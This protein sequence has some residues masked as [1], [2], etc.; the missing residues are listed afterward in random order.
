MNIKKEFCIRTITALTL[1]IVSAIIFFAFP[2]WATS[3]L[4][5]LL[6]TGIFYE[7]ILL[8]R[9]QPRRLRWA[10]QA[11][12]LISW[13]LL[14]LLNQ[15]PHRMLL[16][17]IILVASAHDIGA[18]CIGKLI[19]KHKIAPTISPGKT[20]EGFIGGGITTSFMLIGMKYLGYFSLISYYL[21]FPI[22]FFLSSVATVGDLFESWLKRRAGKKDSGTL[23]PGHGGL[24]DRFDSALAIT[25]VV[26]ILKQLFMLS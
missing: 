2:L 14:L 24:F 1:I 10:V 12:I 21:I 20:W 25:P 15:G 5:I 4:I 3:V 19:G 18:Y 9:Q 16:V 7:A 13:Y 17:F 22:G 26:H 11:Y 6:G 8:T 23:L